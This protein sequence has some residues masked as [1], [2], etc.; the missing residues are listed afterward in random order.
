MKLLWMLCALLV[1]APAYAETLSLSGRAKL[2]NPIVLVHGATIQGSRLQIGP[3]D[4]GDYFKGVAAYLGESGTP[5]RVVELTTDGSIGERAAVLKNYLETDMRNQS[6]NVIAHSLGGLD[7]RYAISI[8]GSKQIAS[9]TTIGTPHR[10]SPLADWAMSEVK[11]KGLWYRF[12]KLLGYDMAG[13]R[14]LPELTL[15][16]MDV[17]NRRV[18]DSPSVKYYSVRTRAS[19]ARG[20]MSYLLWF[21]ARWLEGQHSALAANGH[22]GLVP[23]DSQS[24][25]KELAA[26]EMDH[27]AQMN[28]HEFRRLDMTDDSKRMYQSVYNQLATDGL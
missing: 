13:R 14:F 25:G 21:P 27:L 22:D 5:V 28:H 18:P 17:F 8:L 3:L 7:A 24:W 20:N 11:E 26:L 19:F 9:L 15:A 4:F 6:V 23:Y 10:G 16:G 12:F 1:G 2:K